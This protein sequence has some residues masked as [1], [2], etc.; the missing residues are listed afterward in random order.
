MCYTII[1]VATFR[2]NAFYKKLGPF[3]FH[4]CYN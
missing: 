1:L 2:V 3:V 4:N